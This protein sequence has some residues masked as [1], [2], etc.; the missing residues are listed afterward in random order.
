MPGA[1]LGNLTPLQLDRSAPRADDLSC[2]AR[3]YADIRATLERIALEDIKPRARR[4]AEREATLCMLEKHGLLD[5][6]TGGG[7]ST[8]SSKLQ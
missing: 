7:R 4:R 2:R 6:T 8:R 1:S 3:F 5:R